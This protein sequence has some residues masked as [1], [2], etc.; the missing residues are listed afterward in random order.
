M[1][2]TCEPNCGCECNFDVLACR[3]HR[4]NVARQ[5]AHRRV[6]D[7]AYVNAAIQYEKQQEMGNG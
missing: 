1:L 6:V 3:E 7:E 4:V 5:E 2:P